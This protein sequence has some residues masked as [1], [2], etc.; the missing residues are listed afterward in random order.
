MISQSQFEELREIV[1]ELNSADY[2]QVVMV[3]EHANTAV[4]HSLRADSRFQRLKELI[5]EKF[6]WNDVT[7]TQWT[8]NG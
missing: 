7:P 5:L 8:D 2:K 1:R 6:T 3:G 4:A